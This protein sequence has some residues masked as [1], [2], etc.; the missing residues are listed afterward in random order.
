MRIPL[1][2]VKPQTIANTGKNE[3]SV[4]LLVG[5][6]VVLVFN[7]TDDGTALVSPNTAAAQKATSLFAGVSPAG[8]PV[9]GI[10]SYVSN[11]L[12]SNARL[13]V[14]TRAATTAAWAS[15]AAINAGDQLNMDT[16]N[17]AFAYFAAGSAATNSNSPFAVCAQAVASNASSASNGTSAGTLAYSSTA[18]SVVVNV[19]CFVRSM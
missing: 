7:G 18:T 17:N 19:K 8:A 1:L 5:S 9:N 6:P 14:A 16:A 15:Y 4:A 11:G 2:G 3:D 12:V 13:T 10:F